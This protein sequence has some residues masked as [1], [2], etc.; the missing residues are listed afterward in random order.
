MAPVS[1]VVAVIPGMPAIEF[2]LLASSRALRASTHISNAKMPSTATRMPSMTAT[3]AT[4]APA[5]GSLSC[6]MV[7]GGD[8][9]GAL[10]MAGVSF[11]RFFRPR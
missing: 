8:A 10:L 4:S 3:I 11:S 5:P 1:V 9:Y 2:E 6:L 7:V